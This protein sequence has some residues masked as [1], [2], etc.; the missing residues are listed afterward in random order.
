MQKI[1]P[2]LKYN[3]AQV[4]FDFLEGTLG[5]ERLQVHEG[6]NGGVAHAELRFGDEVLMFGTASEGDPQYNQG[7]GRTVVYVVVEDPDGL[8]ERA[9]G[10][11]AEIVME[12]TDQDYGSRDFVI[13]DPEGNL[14]SFGTYA[15]A[16][17]A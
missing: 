12:P 13:R 15:P 9:K 1:Y 7:I 10:A 14:W 8:F 17:D 4:A 6:D 2:V 11:G 5:C 3:D 16:V